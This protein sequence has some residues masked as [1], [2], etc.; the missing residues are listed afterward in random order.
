MSIVYSQWAL[1]GQDPVLPFHEVLDV[2]DRIG[3]SLD[4]DLLCTA[5]GGHCSAPTAKK[6]ACSF[7]EWHSKQ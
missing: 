3:R 2:A 7:R 1:A 6:L 5:R 4:G